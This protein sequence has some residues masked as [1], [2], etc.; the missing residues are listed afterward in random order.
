MRALVVAG[1]LTLSLAL[2]G[3]ASAAVHVGT[4]QGDVG[5]TSFCTEPSTS[6]A[7]GTVTY[8]DVTHAFSWSY[9]YGDNA[10]DFDNGALYNGGT[11]NGSHFHGPAPIGVHAPIVR[12]LGTGNPNTGSGTINAAD[13]PDLLAGLW[14]LNV[15]STECTGGEIRGQV[16]FPAPVPSGGSVYGLLLAVGLIAIASVAALR[17]RP[18]PAA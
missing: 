16:L 14:F 18:T 15:H 4:I 2:A 12:N 7:I 6:Q 8:D 5:Q 9:T 11:E 13:G 3:A 1:I 10:P 17:S